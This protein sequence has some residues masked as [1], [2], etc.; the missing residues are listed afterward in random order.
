MGY[1]D[2]MWIHR[3]LLALIP[4]TLVAWAFDAGAA[5]NGSGDAW[6]CTAASSV[7]DVQSAVDAAAD[8]A[9]ITFDAGAYDW[10]SA[11]S[12]SND[13]GVTLLCASQGGCTV[14]VDNG[15]VIWLNGTLSGQNDKLYRIS[16]FTF[17]GA[18]AS[19]LAI[20]FWGPGTLSRVRIDHNTFQS[21]GDAAVSI[22]FGETSTIGSYYGVIDHNTVTGPSN[23]LLL[24][25]FGAVNDSPPPSPKG[26]ANNMFVEDN[27]MSFTTI[28]NTGAGCADS[29]GGASIVWRHNTTTNCLVTSH[30]VVHNGG[31]FNWELYDNSFNVDSGATGSEDCYRCFHH[32][33]SGEFIAFDN[34]FTAAG[35][36]NQTAISMTHYRAADPTTAGYD[37]P[38]GRCDGTKS[39]DANRAPTSTYYGYPCWR[40]PGR[41][42]AGNLQPMYIWNNAWSDT[43]AKVDMVVENPW[44]AVSPSVDDHI[45]PDRDY[46]NAVSASAQTSATS[47]FDGTTGMGFGTLANRP[48]TCTTNPLEPGGGVG[49]FATD[50]GPE[51]TLYRCSATNTW[52]VQYTP[53]VYPHPLVGGAAGQPGTGGSGGG[54]GSAGQSAGGTGGSNS[55]GGAAASSQKSASDSGDSGCGCRLARDGARGAGGWALWV[56]GAAA[57]AF[58]RAKRR[59]SRG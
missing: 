35:G 47:P 3:H 43:K 50:D 27:T 1:H 51:G 45:A 46:Y 42:G 2:D 5:C 8:A 32:Q 57:W 16:G 28:T 37:D 29:W 23:F 21:F 53:Y 10:T 34:T 12:L 39:I 4:L 14:T 56:I 24:H 54:G 41:D 11:V 13:R 7:A 6:Q 55:S 59:A 19:A 40:Q 26:T 52:S 33:G 25:V 36:K 30:G 49:Y 15:T 22:A 17:Q 31:P 9:T 18:P 48:T 44:N 20:W 58:G 38:P